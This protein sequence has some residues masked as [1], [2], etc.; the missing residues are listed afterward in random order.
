MPRL[1]MF[2]DDEQKRGFDRL[3]ENPVH[4]LDAARD[5]DVPQLKFVAGNRE[6][7]DNSV[8]VPPSIRLLS[9]PRA[10]ETGPVKRRDIVVDHRQLR[11]AQGVGRR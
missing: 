5:L 8:V 6:P 4:L 2:D 1:R 11:L 10:D 3:K 9:T 7:I